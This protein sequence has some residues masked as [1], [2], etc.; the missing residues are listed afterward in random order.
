MEAT[1]Q[2]NSFKSSYIN[3]VLALFY[4]AEGIIK[5][6]QSRI[7]ANEENYKGQLLHEMNQTE[8]QCCKDNLDRICGQ[9]ENLRDK[10][11]ELLTKQKENDLRQP[12]NR[13]LEN[14]ANVKDIITES[15]LQLYADK[16]KESTL[17]QRRIQ[18]IATERGFHINTYPEYDKKLETVQEIASVFSDYI[19]YKNFGLEPAIYEKTTLMEYDNILKPMEAE[20]E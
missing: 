3:N 15:E 17:V 18:S 7:A 11:M 10:E 12:P 1:Q 5:D 14:L 20:K 6:S 9:I 8:E 13:T 19:R 2:H 16:C 4:S